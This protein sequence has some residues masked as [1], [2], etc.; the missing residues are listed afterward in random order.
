MGGIYTLGVQPGTILRNNL[1]HDISAFTYGG[2]GIY[3]DEGSSDILIEN[4]VVYNCKSANFHQHYGREN[5]V[6]N[7]IF[8]FGKES[9]LMRTRTEE[10]VS[11]N[12][13]RNIVY[14]KDGALLGSN[15]NDNNYHLDGN[16]Y[17]KV[18]GGD[19]RFGKW[20]FEEWKAK[21]Q[22]VHS[23]IE[24]PLFVDPEKRDFSLKPES[25]ALKMGFM[26]IDVSG[27][28]PRP[29]FRRS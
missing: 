12:L 19:V 29:E 11:F 22:D 28:G 9:Q 23:S 3:P 6:R 15:W 16:L 1:I 18:G 14:W 26:P 21:G 24:D 2:W 5:I 13:E 25:P 17:W 4:N 27:V 10:H 20:S 8:A 7:N